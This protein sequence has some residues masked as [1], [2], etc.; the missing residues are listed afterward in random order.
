MSTTTS[1]AMNG[2]QGLRR[3]ESVVSALLEHGTMSRTELAEITG[4]S[5]SSMTGSIR[6]LIRS[7][8]VRETGRG[9]S[10]GGR[11]RTLL[12][13]DRRSVLLM[14]LSVD[15]G[16]VVARQVDLA[17]TV[18][19]QVRRR[20]DPREPLSSVANAITAL[21]GVS[22]SPSS[23][24]VISLPGVVSAEGDVSLAPALGDL[25][26]RRVQDVVAETSGLHTF[27][28]NDVNLLA[29]GESM[30]G[31]AKDGGDFGLIYIGDG[32]GGALV[33]DG[34][35]RR[36]ATGSAGEIG[37][38]PWKGAVAERNSAIGPLEADWSVPALCA[39]AEKIGIDAGDQ[40]VITALEQS[41]TA[42]A[43]QL[44]E[45]AL[46][47]WAYPAFVLTCVVNPGRIVFA[48]DASVLCPQSRER[49]TA[50]VLDGCPSPVEICFA[51]L[52]EGA[53][54]SGAIAHLHGAPWIFLPVTDHRSEPPEGSSRATDSP[55]ALSEDG[56]TD[57]PL[58]TI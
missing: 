21:Q 26:A 1:T 42:E 38:L 46:A 45:D 22:E 33:L 4:C 55:S 14:L 16:H 44:L 24:A 2:A 56:A 5:Q 8:H 41:A 37:F 50:H 23:C 29:L 43:Q 40:H 6:T 11:R 32:I 27:A 10:T 31:A 34:N 48:G 47:A 51:E 35:V 13:F 49:L 58:P 25:T 3:L 28:E 17:A 19:A 52:G 57:Q 18:H 7:G 54:V 53:I 30:E 15:A 36:G 20:L 12:E 39:K 9:R